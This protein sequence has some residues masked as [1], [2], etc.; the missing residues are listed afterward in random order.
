MK[1]KMLYK[2]WL[3]IWLDQKEGY[4]KDATFAHYTVMV[5]NHLIPTLGDL[6][7]SQITEKRLQKAVLEW[8]ENGR[9]D[10]VGG[11]AEKTV[12]DLVV[13]VRRSMKDAAKEHLVSK[14][15]FEIAYPQNDKEE[16]LKVLTKE[17]QLMLTQYVYLNLTPKNAGILFCLHTGVRIGELCALQWKD[18]DMENKV[19]HI[20]KTLQRI[21]VKRIDGKNVT[22]VN[23]SSPKSKSSIRT[24]PLSTAI[25]PVL[26]RLNPCDD[27]KYLLTN[28][29]T[30][31][32]PR[33]YRDFFERFLKKLK[34][35]HINFHSLRHT[36]KACNRTYKRLS[37]KREAVRR[38]LVCRNFFNDFPQFVPSC[39][40]FAAEGYKYILAG[41]HKT[42]FQHG[43][44]LRQLTSFE[45]IRLCGC[46]YNIVGI[47]FKPFIHKP[48]IFARLMP[49]VYK[50]YY[51]S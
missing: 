11:L 40:G 48:V 2:D 3:K 25:Y 21:F 28:K 12:K 33:T 46:D 50:Q 16:K 17:Q 49:Y 5:I 9:L 13:I 45:L 23:I 51:S 47:M 20:D 24:I 42:F 27:E 39:L 30:Y 26:K 37:I 22:R 34:I 44:V 31:T 8:L 4:V 19:V 14:R 15:Q 29:T 35:E 38:L 1:E 41:K 18:I 36:E 10:S 43:N 32:E 6:Y 7:L